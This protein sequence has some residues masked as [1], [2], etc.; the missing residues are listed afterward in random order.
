MG[1]KSSSQ[2]D[3]VEKGK[4]ELDFLTVR[5]P[6]SVLQAAIWLT[7]MGR[8]WLKFFYSKIQ[9]PRSL[10]FHYWIIFLGLEDF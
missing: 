9:T 4:S 2:V 1:Q 8:G 3:I 6:P 7:D 5:L 10:P